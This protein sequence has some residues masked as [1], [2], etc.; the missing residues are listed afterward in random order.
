[1]LT[2]KPL[3]YHHGPVP[4]L[5]ACALLL[6]AAGC[7]APIPYSPDETRVATL[8]REEAK[9]RLVEVATR[10]AQ[11]TIGAAS[12]EDDYFVFHTRQAVMGAFY[13]VHET[14]APVTIAYANLSRVEIYPNHW[15][16]VYG[17]GDRLLAQVLFANAEDARVF[18]DLLMSF[19]AERLKRRSTAESAGST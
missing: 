2:R 11:P 15:V 12:V 4:S 17:A 14:T 19:R 6:G 16:Y 13:M 18:S 1:M 7:V 9:S 8:G 5:F 10:A 3:V